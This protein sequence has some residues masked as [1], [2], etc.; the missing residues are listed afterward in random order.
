MKK[1]QGFSLIEIMLGLLVAMVVVTGILVL[2]PKTVNNNKADQEIKNISTL[3][4]GINAFYQ[5]Q[6][7]YSTV[8]NKNML[9]ASVV[10]DSMRLSA[11]EDNGFYHIYNAWKGEV[12][13][14]NAN[15]QI[16]LTQIP[17]ALYSIE[18]QG[19]PKEDCIK[20][21][22]ALKGNNFYWISVNESNV[23]SQSHAYDITETSQQCN[24]SNSNSITFY[25]I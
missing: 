13:L 2:Y 5:G 19:V 8:D 3:A 7:N 14:S 16:G 15:K 21:V 12:I 23:Y 10:P 4:I 20:L 17:A 9:N 11:K 6:P 18:Y 25:G 24:K 1:H 22:S